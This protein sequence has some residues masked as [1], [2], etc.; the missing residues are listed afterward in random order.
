MEALDQ[1]LIE[2]YLA[3]E[4]TAIEQSVFEKRLA[5]E[6]GL[7]QEFEEYKLVMEAVKLAERQELLQRF[8]DRDK[9]LDRKT[10]L[11]SLHPNRRIWMLSAAAIL[12]MIIAWRFFIQPGHNSDQAQQFPKDSTN[13][14]QPLP[15]QQDTLQEEELNKE[16]KEE[17]KPKTNKPS[18]KE[19]YADNFEP[20][21]DESLNPTSRSDEEEM[22]AFEKFQLSYW[23]RNYNDALA[24]FQ[25]LSPALQENDNLRFL[26]AIALMALSQVDEAAIILEEVS[27]N[28]KSTY[29]TEA[30]YYLA[31]CYVRNEQFDSARKKLTSYLSDPDALKKDKAKTLLNDLK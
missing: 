11:R 18:G 2:R 7:Q 25:K 15:I 30:V 4:M 10:G 12:M 8:R 19:L 5:L 13:I 3:N 9:I 6:S 28:P 31:L 17:V 16:K 24:A 26:R 27:K 20:Y 1:T 14:Q 29:K 21:M 23:K 22:S